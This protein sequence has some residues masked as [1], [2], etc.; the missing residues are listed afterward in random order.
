MCQT[1]SAVGGVDA[2]AAGAGGAEGVDAH[3]A[4]V[5]FHVELLGLGEHHHAGGGGVD[6]ALGLGGGDALYAVH[7]A[8]VL[9]QTVGAVAGDGE[10][11]VLVAAR[12]AFVEVIDLY[13]PVLLLAEAGVHAEEVAGE[14]AG[15]VTA[16]AAANLHHSIFRVGGISGDEQQADVLLHGLA[17]LLSGGELLL[18]HLAQFGVFLALEQFLALGDGVEQG[19]IFVVGFHH[20]LQVLVVLRQFYIAF[21][22]RS[23]LRVVHLLLNLLVTSVYGF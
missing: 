16:R 22:V 10:G 4:H 11:D 23:D 17:T 9:Q 8:F 14:D 12:G 5:Q 2:L 20:G 15:L 6:A 3:V 21:H 18:G 1:H 13:L 7:A 19:F